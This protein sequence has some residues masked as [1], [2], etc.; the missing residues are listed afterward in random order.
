MVTLSGQ[1]SGS[2][3]T[4]T[5]LKLSNN[6][7]YLSKFEII[8][9]HNI[10]EYTN[11]HFTSS[12][13]FNNALVGSPAGGFTNNYSNSSLNTTNLVISNGNHY[14]IKFNLNVFR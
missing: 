2:T 9:S 12:L 5:S 14:P 13:Y 6:Q 11:G 10:N 3:V 8:I 1:Y 4:H 7:V